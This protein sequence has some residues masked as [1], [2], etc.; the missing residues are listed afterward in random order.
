[1]KKYRFLM[2]MSLLS[3]L[4]LVL[5]PSAGLE[6]GQLTMKS[7][8]EMLILL[9]P[10]LIIVGLLDK[11]IEKDT[12][13]RYMGKD[14]GIYGILFALLLGTIAAGPLYIAF[15]IAVLLLKKGAGVRYI[16]FFLGVWSTAKL[17]VVI[18]ELASFGIKFTMI[19]ISF[20]LVF[21]YI[22]G[23]VFERFYHPQVFLKDAE[24]G[25]V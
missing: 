22:L 13:I 20:G 3:V 7:I 25:V 16:V 2:I 5:K 15:P 12:L 18:Y 21:A 4:L 8:M 11:W 14:S 6:A 24:A 1:M 17:P 19:H 10:I 23:V 9:P